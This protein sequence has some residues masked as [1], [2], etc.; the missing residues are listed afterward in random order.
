MGIDVH[1]NTPRG[2]LRQIQAV[3]RYR[4]GGFVLFSFNDLPGRDKLLS[5]LSGKP[6]VTA[7]KPPLTD[8]EAN[9]A[10]SRVAF[11]KGIRSAEANQLG[12]ARVYLN[13]AITLDPNYAE[14]YFRLG[15]CY[16]RENN[17]GKARELYTKTLEIDPNHAGAKAELDALGPTP[18]T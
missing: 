1:H 6:W 16:F 17:R 15:R 11:E 10:E 5:A 7:A 14:A 8:Q 12:M 4:L 2:I 13:Q 9:V 18:S 3:K